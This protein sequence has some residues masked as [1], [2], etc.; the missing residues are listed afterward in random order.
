MILTVYRPRMATK[1]ERTIAPKS[2]IVSGPEVAPGEVVCYFEGNTIGAGNL[3]S[4]FQK[5][6]SAAGRLAANYPTA[7]CMQVAV[8]DLHAIAEYDTERRA[9]SKVIDREGLEEWAGEPV[10]SIAG[11]RLAPGYVSWT[12]GAD[13]VNGGRIISGTLG[14]DSRAY[15]SRAGQVFVFWPRAETGQR[16]EVLADDD[17]RMQL[18]LEPDTGPQSRWM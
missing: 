8:Q 16:V 10:E 17:P 5:L 11:K 12:V 1:A 2:A 13:A 9:I 3:F 4:F 15:W 7:A 14:E 6:L 18:F